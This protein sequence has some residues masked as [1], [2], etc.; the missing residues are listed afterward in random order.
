[1]S[2]EY[3]AF[4]STHQPDSVAAWPE[5]GVMSF[6]C[7]GKIHYTKHP[8]LSTAGSKLVTGI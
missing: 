6:V 7:D 4:V 1:M 5:E 3:Q 2:L 8:K